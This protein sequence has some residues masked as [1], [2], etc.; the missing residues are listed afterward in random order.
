MAFPDDC[1][2]FFTCEDGKKSKDLTWDQFWKFLIGSDS[3]GCPVLRTDATGGGGGGGAV[4]LPS[5]TRTVSRTV[6]TG[7]GAGSVASGARSVTIELSNDFAGSLL[8]DADINNGGT[9][10]P[11]ASYNFA[12]S[13]NDDVLGAIGYILTSGKITITKIV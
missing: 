4:T 8:G 7:A 2:S 5:T 11:G 12:V 3:N 6:V 13:Q 9:V 1:T 10:I